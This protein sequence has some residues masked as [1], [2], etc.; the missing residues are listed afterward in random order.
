MVLGLLI[1][2]STEGGG[3][4]E[5]LEPVVMVAASIEPFSR[6]LP[7]I[8]G[9]RRARCQRRKS[10]SKAQARQRWPGAVRVLTVVEVTV[11]RTNQKQWPDRVGYAVTRKR[12]D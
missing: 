4:E 8:V 2:A 9:N 3:D 5:V 6:A 10:W 11:H 7:A 1:P 12:R